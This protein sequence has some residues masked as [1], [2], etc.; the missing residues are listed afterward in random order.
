MPEHIEVTVAG[1]IYNNVRQAWREISPEGLPEIT[2]RKRLDAGW[3]ELAAFTLAPIPA[4]ERRLGHEMSET[5][6]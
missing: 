6:I 1:V 2:V 4:P 3:P 5:D